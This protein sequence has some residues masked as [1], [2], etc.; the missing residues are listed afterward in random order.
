MARQTNHAFLCI[1]KRPD[2]SFIAG[3]ATNQSGM[4]LMILAVLIVP[5]GDVLSK[6]LAAHL[7]PIEIAFY[8][9]TVQ[10]VFL[11][12]AL[13]L[14]RVNLRPRKL[15]LLILGGAMS[16]ATLVMLIG[17]FAVMPVATAIAIFFVEPLILTVLS[18]LL[19]GEKAGWRRY[20]AI[21]VGMIGALVVIRP[22]WST[23]GW[24]AIFPLFAA[25]SFAILA[26]VIRKLSPVMSGLS[27]QFWF[28]I[29]ASGLLGV[30]LGGA[31]MLGMFSFSLST[32]ESGLYWVIPVQGLLSA[33]TFFLFT[34]AF[35][36]TEASV[37]APFQYGE[38]I[39]A[40]VLGYLVFGDFPDGMTWLG[41]AIILAS[42]LYVFS[43]ER[44]TR[45]AA[46]EMARPE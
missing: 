38:I 35:R 27:I 6:V 41:T 18:V 33:F 28:S 45:M 11:G 21:A 9:F 1:M 17:A 26:V 15:G 16:A 19:L 32:L 10:A 43:R 44:R 5:A 37:L 14:F 25:L 39:G 30:G 34:E 13:P 31:A 23:F 4:A 46:N 40:T 24:P 22:N 42:G 7:H 3:K 8:R 29:A 36:R 2:P 12:L 20:L